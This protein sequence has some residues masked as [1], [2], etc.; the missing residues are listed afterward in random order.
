M[1]KAIAEAKVMELNDTLFV[2]LERWAEDF[3]NFEN[4]SDKL[5]DVYKTL[6]LEEVKEYW[7]M[8]ESVE[9]DLEVSSI[10]FEPLD[11]STEL[12]MLPDYSFRM[13]I[14]WHV[15]SKEE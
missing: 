5:Y 7:E 8:F 10:E 11:D 15:R 2:E 12:T 3:L 6:M 4:P 1:E 14:R 13:S 9:P